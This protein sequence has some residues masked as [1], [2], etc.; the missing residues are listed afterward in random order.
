MYKIMEKHS[1]KLMAIF[2]ALLM[3]VFIIPNNNRSNRSPSDIEVGQIGSQTITADQLKFASQEWNTL[4]QTAF[5]EV[6]AN[7]QTGQPELA[8]LAILLDPYHNRETEDFIIGQINK[9]PVMFLLLLREAQRNGVSVSNESLSGLLS[10]VQVQLSDRRVQYQ[11]VKDDETGDFVRQA[12][13]DLL[14]IQN[15]YKQS[16]DMIKISRPLLDNQLARTVQ[17]IKLEMVEFDGKEFAN[18]VPAPTTQQLTDQFNRYADH[19]PGVVDPKTDPAG[20]GYKYPNRVKLAYIE[21]P[22]AELR[23]AVLA[24]QTNDQWQVDEWRYYK[25]HISEFPATA[26]A[27]QPTSKPTDAFTLGKQATT[28]PFN[29][30][31]SDVLNDLVDPQAD[32]LAQQIES[33][34]A[35]QMR[36]DWN[37]YHNAVTATPPTTAPASSTGVPY[38]SPD[39]LSKL[40]AQVQSDFKVIPTVVNLSQK[41]LDA[42]E[43]E[44]LSGI[45]KSTVT[46]GNNGEAPFAPYAIQTAAPFAQASAQQSDNLLQLLEPSRPLKNDDDTYIFRLTAVDPAHKPA[47]LAEVQPQVEKDVRD[48]AAYAMAQATAKSTLAAAQSTTISAAAV[49]ASKTVSDTGYFTLRLGYGATPPVSQNARG[50]FLKQA[51]DLLGVAATGKKPIELIDVPQDQK[52]FVA[53]LVNVQRIPELAGVDVEPDAAAGIT[54]DLS[55]VLFFQWYN[56]DA[57]R[58]R[59][60]YKDLGKNSD[61]G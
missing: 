16:Q 60:D 26:P 35:L 39:Y 18:K 34:I 6:G 5:I 7:P 41:F 32:Q 8:P 37:A 1:K 28:R 14:M 31:Q 49:K 13:H 51:F 27:S 44:N 12:A 36:D 43:L 25:H 23:K 56:Y 54:E 55:Q 30:V 57:I 53:Q 24:S 52:V 2:A 50:V 15:A 29:E 3:I 42:T 38:D 19:L 59:M 11:D 20:Y 46:L 45:G 9:H 21:I 47:T 40:A 61:Q 33:K 58:Q 17:Q 4:M 10:V 48:A 22:R